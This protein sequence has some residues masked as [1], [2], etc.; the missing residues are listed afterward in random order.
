V[1]AEGNYRENYVWSVLV[2]FSISTSQYGHYWPVRKGI[3]IFLAAMF[4]YGLHINT[5]YHSYLINVLQN[6]RYDDQIDTIQ[7]AID[8]GMSFEI[9]ENIIEF[10]EEKKDPVR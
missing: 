9:G 8:V 5:A 4:F 6:P 3:R 7:K 2:T 1:R 10:L